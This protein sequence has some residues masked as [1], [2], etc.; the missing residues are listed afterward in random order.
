MDSVRSFRAS[1]K[2][3]AYVAGH[4]LA[5]ETGCENSSFYGAVFE[6]KSEKSLF[7]G[8]LGACGFL[9]LRPISSTPLRIFQAFGLS[10]NGSPLKA[11]IS[12]SGGSCGLF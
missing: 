12:Q 10:Q 8:V 6:D 1:S 2:L 9:G 11:R 3:F 7:K 5:A 4:C